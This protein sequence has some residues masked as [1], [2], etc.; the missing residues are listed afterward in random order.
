MVARCLLLVVGVCCRCASAR[1]ERRSIGGS[2]TGWTENGA[3][4]EVAALCENKQR[5]LSP[6]EAMSKLIWFFFPPLICKR[7]IAYAQ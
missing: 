4:G 6:G 5:A 3:D 7:I 1:L 2:V